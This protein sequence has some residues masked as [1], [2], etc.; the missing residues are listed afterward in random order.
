LVIMGTPLI[1][2]VFGRTITREFTRG[3][4]GCSDAYFLS[5][6]SGIIPDTGISCSLHFC[7]LF[8]S[9]NPDSLGK[10]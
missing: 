4:M 8:L 9:S 2:V 7:P 6:L 1:L 3:K 5:F 10:H